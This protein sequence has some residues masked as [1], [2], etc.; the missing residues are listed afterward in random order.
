MTVSGSRTIGGR[1]V[2]GFAEVERIEDAELLAG[3]ELR[4]PESALRPLQAGQYYQHQLAGCVVQTTSGEPVGTVSRIEG[5]F[6]GSRLVVAGERG[7]VLVP[8]VT[9]ICR[10]VDVV[11][12]RIVIDPP[13]GL[14]DLN[15]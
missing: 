1:L 11:G 14:L 10:E 4:I 6:G 2:V 7:E 3:T 13:E 8:F 9:P 12:R 5:G 15:R